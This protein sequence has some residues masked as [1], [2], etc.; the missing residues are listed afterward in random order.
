MN[1]SQHGSGFSF[2]YSNSNN[3]RYCAKLLSPQANAITIASVMLPLYVVVH[4][5][6][7]VI[8]R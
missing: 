6:Q 8:S 2:S 5:H 3:A 1:Q 4:E 7:L